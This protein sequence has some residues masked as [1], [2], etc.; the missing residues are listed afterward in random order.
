MKTDQKTQKTTKTRRPQKPAETPE[1]RL[2]QCI[3]LAYD[4]AYEQLLDG[5][6]SSQVI[7]HFLKCGEEERELEREMMRKQM[8]L[9]DKKIEAIDSA[10]DM[11]QMLVDATE[12]FK[13]YS[14]NGNSVDFDA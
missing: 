10:E 11:K 1:G 4:V 6:A 13:R 14:G 3:A 7:T 5:T 12:A 9:I 2:K 8:Q